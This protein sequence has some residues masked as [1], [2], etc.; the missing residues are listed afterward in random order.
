MTKKLDP[1]NPG[2]KYRP[3]PFWSW[4]DK[5]DPEELRK[6]VR[7]MHEAGMGGFFMHARGGLQT[8]YLSPEWMT[9][10][11]AC[12]DEAGKLGMSG[13]LYDENGWP[14]GFGGGLVNGLGLQYQQKYLRYEIAGAAELGTENTIA[15]Y[16]PDGQLLGRTLPA[17]TSGP[18]LRCYF[19]VN[20]YYVDNLD[21]AVVKEFLR[22]THEFYY[23]NIPEKLLKHLKGIF[24]DEP[25]L[26]RDGLLWSFVLEREYRAA[27]R[28][29]LLKDLPML[30]LGSDQSEAM[31]IRFWSLASRLFRD[32]FMKQIHDWCDAHGW[33]LTGHHVLEETCHGQ[34]SCNG[35][36][37]PQYQYY[38]IPGMD[39]LG[40]SKPN[41]VTMTQL[42]S[43]A[44]QF[45]QK[46]LLTESFAMTGWN[47]N[48]SGMCWMYQQQ[49]AHGVNLLCQHLESYSL[50]G[51]RK[52]DY[53]CSSFVH[54][55]WWKDYRRVNDYFSRAGMMLAEGT[56][57][58]EILVVHPI[59]SVWALYNGGKADHLSAWYTESLKK[60]TEALDSLQLPHHYA[61]ELI[62]ESCGSLKQG[63]IRI[64]KCSY[65][66]VV[67]PPVTNISGKMLELL[68]G[69]TA[70]GGTVL[71][72]RNQ[73]EPEKLT[74][75][76]T[77]ASG[78]VRAWFRSLPGFDSERAA[79]EAAA[80]YLPD[81]VR[82]TQNGIP[83]EQMAS[84]S[85]RIG[86]LA[87]G[88]SG[89][90]YL[91]ANT[92]YHQ[93]CRTV[94]SLPQTGRQVELIDPETGAM[95]LLDGVRRNGKTL[96]F[97]YPFGPGE[98]AMFFVSDRPVRTAAKIKIED[99][100]RLPVRKRLASIFR[101]GAVTP[102]NLLTL[103]RCRYRVDRSDWICDDVSVIHS[104]LLQLRKDCDLEMEFEFFLDD[105]F[106]LSLPLTLVTETP[107]QFKFQLNGKAFT[108]ADGGECFDQAFRKIKLPARL[109]HGVNVIRLKTRYHQAP[110][111]YAALDRAQKFETEYNKLTFDS[112]I[113]NVYLLGDFTVRHIGRVEPLPR[114]AERF[115]GK[116][117]LGGA[118]TGRIDGRDLVCA[119]FPFF[120]GSMTLTQ[121]FRLTGE[122]AGTIRYLRFVP[123]GANSWRIR[124]NGREAGFLYNGKYSVPT[125]G[126]L[127]QGKNT[128]EFELTT[129]LRNLLGP[130]HLEEGESYSV[131]TIS[132]SKETISPKRA[133]PP[134]NDGY[135][136]VR[137][138][139]DRIE[140]V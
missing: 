64:G 104:R 105:S 130:H 26:S 116:F 9:C 3:V 37:M 6:Q 35:S 102:G 97:E 12:L 117:I 98:G 138:G 76:G 86:S 114:L 61:D 69:F 115:H 120:A 81:R 46:Q 99:V 48:F 41:P 65:S 92:Q 23:R 39:H 82:I 53:P 58:T 100:D 87:D 2:M 80:G 19:T 103:D 135:C 125:A 8:A 137:L 27:Y 56:A 29:D 17:G 4:N 55:P 122:E 73:L 131:A 1:A 28:R 89:M 136:F 121:E 94:I 140:L 50:R 62:A 101:T 107:D 95:S 14:S 15:Y 11:N 31:R 7:A 111:V 18:V 113:E 127:R 108:A 79:A 30:F 51:L 45:G 110:E 129:S 13:W 71:C 112:E 36:I 88:R 68:R 132:F 91:I 126:L 21:A 10:V 96:E 59:S 85:R 72:V 78:E 25:Q 128:I 24:T 67:I 5:L 75:D 90:F 118:E 16:T 124:I 109:K 83:A 20:P 133:A 33:L 32:H 139:L 22:V 54:Q 38:H 106:D 43:A 119:G 52:R 47:F 134:Y 44:M 70:A 60:L 57:Q 77:P 74:V 40:R 84:A 93:P 49:L 63:K 42:V 123:F 34:I 66:L